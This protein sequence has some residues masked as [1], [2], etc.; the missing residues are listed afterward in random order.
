MT[1]T[2][3]DDHE[4]LTL[5]R[6][7]R[8]IARYRPEIGRIAH[9]ETSPPGGRD[10]RNPN[11]YGSRPP[12]HLGAIHL[13]A[14]LDTTMWSWCRLLRHELGITCPDPQIPTVDGRDIAC[15]RGGVGARACAPPVYSRCRARA[16]TDG[17]SARLL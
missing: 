5:T 14:D 8:Y 15:R 6:D 7:L 11:G 4:T 10:A 12:G 17:G 1:D 3:L 9:R 13:C 2:F 16:S